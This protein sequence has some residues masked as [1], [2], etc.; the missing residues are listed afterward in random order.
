MICSKIRAGLIHISH[1]NYSCVQSIADIFHGL[2]LHWIFL[3]NSITHLWLP[4]CQE[5]H[6]IKIK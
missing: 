2:I 3:K 6:R 5:M 1:E 4:Q